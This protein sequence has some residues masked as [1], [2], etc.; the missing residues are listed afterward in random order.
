MKPGSVWYQ[1]VACTGNNSIYWAAIKRTIIQCQK[2]IGSTSVIS[3]ILSCNLTT[4]SLILRLKILEWKFVQQLGTVLSFRDRCFETPKSW[5]TVMFEAFCHDFG[6]APSTSNLSKTWKPRESR[7]VV[8]NLRKYH[9]NYIE[10]YG[11]LLRLQNLVHCDDWTFVCFKNQSPLVA[12]WNI[13]SHLK[14]LQ[15]RQQ[16]VFSRRGLW[17]R[18]QI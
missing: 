11:K 14:S 17:Q 5:V 8:L 18:R 9:N 15:E 3:L 12:G 2:E 6:T 13:L 1:T 7:G 10:F 16:Q 4:P